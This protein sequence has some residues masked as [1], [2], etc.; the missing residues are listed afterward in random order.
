MLNG[1][2]GYTT[3]PSKIITGGGGGSGAAATCTT[4]GNSVNGNTVI[5]YGNGY[6]TLPTGT[7]TQQVINTTG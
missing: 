6:S 7:F 3:A 5:N 2:A 1:G 4:S